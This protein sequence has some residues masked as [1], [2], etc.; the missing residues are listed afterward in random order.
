MSKLIPNLDILLQGLKSETMA[1]DLASAFNGDETTIEDAKNRLRK[2]VQDK[3][4]DE[5]S[6]YGK[7]QM[8]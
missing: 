1:H 2:I 3:I 6:H 4:E 5:R 8:D 7:T